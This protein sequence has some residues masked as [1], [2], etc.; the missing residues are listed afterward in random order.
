GESAVGLAREEVVARALD[1]RSGL[2]MHAGDDV[3]ADRCRLL[4]PG[5]ENVVGDGI[6][7]AGDAG[8]VEL[9]RAHAVLARI[10][11]HFG[12]L[13]L[14]EDL[15]VEDGVDVA[16]LVHGPAERRQMQKI[17]VFEAPHHDADGGDAAENRRAGFALRLVFERKLVAD[18]DVRIE[19]SRQHHLAAG[20]EH[21]LRRSGKLLADGGNAAA[22][23]ADVRRHGADAGN[24]ERAVADNEIEAGAHDWLAL[25][26]WRAITARLR[27]EQ[28][29]RAQVWRVAAMVP[30]TDAPA[31]GH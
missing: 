22:T 7:D 5:E 11:R 6:D 27:V 10:V 9:E 30:L 8:H 18:V 14:G 29:T 16:R 17:R 12:D 3:T 24:D 20:I 26:R 4:E 31:S 21:V 23:D 19:D 25:S 28:A 2:A 1:Q 13:L 15:Q